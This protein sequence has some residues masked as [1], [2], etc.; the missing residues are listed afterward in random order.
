MQ[1]DG[2]E[3]VAG[4]ALSDEKLQRECGARLAAAVAVLRADPLAAAERAPALPQL[5]AA[6]DYNGFFGGDTSPA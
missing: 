6:L 3:D 4:E 2:E 1:A 5:L